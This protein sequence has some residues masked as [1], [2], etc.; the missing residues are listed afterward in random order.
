LRTRRLVIFTLLIW[1]L[2]AALAS[3]VRFRRYVRSESFALLLADYLAAPLGATPSIGGRAAPDARTVVL[4]DLVL[5]VPE[6]GAGGRGEET[7]IR[8]GTVTFRWRRYAG[9]G[10]PRE[11]AI[12][13]LR[14]DLRGR[15]A[16]LYR[17]EEGPAAL[18][19]ALELIGVRGD[20]ILGEGRL[21]MLDLAITG[22]AP[23]RRIA[24]TARLGEGA[25][26]IRG[27]L[28]RGGPLTVEI[29]G[30]RLER[31]VE[32]MRSAGLTGLSV[33]ARGEIST[34]AGTVVIPGEPD[35]DWGAYLKGRTRSCRVGAGGAVSFSSPE[36]EF[37]VE[38]GEGELTASVSHEKGSACALL[39]TGVEIPL[40]DAKAEMKSSSEGSRLDAELALPDGPP[41]RITCDTHTTSGPPGPPVL[42]M[43][44]PR[45]GEATTRRLLAGLLGWTDLPP[46]IG[47]SVSARITLGGTGPS[48]DVA[49]TLTCP[50]GG[51]A[52][53]RP[54][55]EV[56]GHLRAAGPRVG[57]DSGSM[58]FTAPPTSWGQGFNLSRL[59][60][61]RGSLSPPEKPG[62]RWRISGEVTELAY[63]LSGRE[64]K[65]APPVMIAGEFTREAGGLR[66]KELTGS[67]PE[68]WTARFTGGTRASAEGH[69]E[70][71][72][73]FVMTGTPVKYVTP[74][75][76]AGLI[77][78]V[79]DLSGPL[80]SVKWKL[81]RRKAT[82]GHFRTGDPEN[83]IRSLEIEGLDFEITRPPP[84]PPKPGDEGGGPTN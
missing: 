46:G 27:E 18:P 17:A 29:S 1:A 15:L 69:S 35:G 33:G 67:G 41:A 68:G 77:D 25:L 39:L 16:D 76:D 63:K 50:S 58:S 36:S 48:G 83:I 19:E 80:R 30:A 54:F 56:R 31:A 74:R 3:A 65:L 59:K 71:T 6:E 44:W 9:L 2:S 26:S 38:A 20:I 78:S 13:G 12:E 24:C 55:L 53:E 43:R 28:R 5:R 11:I 62:G 10:W 84:P 82:G 72:G 34:L 81:M 40:S 22:R 75:L 73:T 52:A 32:V 49:V 51:P 66:F 70:L 4:K 47:G 7:V 64:V 21:T 8:A 60:L 14:A 61:A 45:T 42:E 57:F 37:T 23:A 79:Y